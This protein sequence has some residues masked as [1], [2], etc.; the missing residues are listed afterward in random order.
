MSNGSNLIRK[1]YS[2]SVSSLTMVKKWLIALALV[3]AV[4]SSKSHLSGEELA[5]VSF[6]AHV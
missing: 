6:L 4:D 2:G 3:G 5:T 1:D